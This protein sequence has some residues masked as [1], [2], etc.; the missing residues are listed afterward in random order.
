VGAARLATVV[1]DQG[2]GDGTE[3]GWRDQQRLRLVVPAKADRAVTAAARAP[4]AASAGLPIGR[5]AHTVRQGPGNTAWTARQETAVVGITG[6]T[7][8][9]Q[10]G[11]PA[12]G[13][14]THRREFQGHRITAVVGRRWTGRDDGPGGNTVC[15][16]KAAV[17]TPLPPFADDDERRLLANGGIKA[18]KQPWDLGHPPQNTERAV[19][20][21]VLFPRRMFALAT[22]YRRPC[23][24]EA[25][26]GE[27]F[28]RQRGRRQ[29]LEHTRDTVMVCAQ[30][31]DGIVHLAEYAWR[32]GVRLKDTPPGVG[33]YPDM[34]AKYGLTSQA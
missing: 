23:E 14:H 11:T 6:L 24:R 25:T 34:L 17:D 7:T 27:P 8:D 9:A 13:R 18:A 10:E 30:G 29:R 21:H 12:H 32:L 16:T 20:V 15:L 19:W 33:T 2:L 3:L 5:R 22:A 4:A 28:G 26:G 1:V 31:Y